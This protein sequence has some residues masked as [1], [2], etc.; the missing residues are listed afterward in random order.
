MVKQLNNSLFNDIPC[1]VYL[2]TNAYGVTLDA[3]VAIAGDPSLYSQAIKILSKKPKYSPFLLI[4]QVEGKQIPFVTP[5]GVLLLAEAWGNHAL[6]SLHGWLR[7]A[8]HKLA[9]HEEIEEPVLHA[10]AILQEEPPLPLHDETDRKVLD[11]INRYDGTYPWR[12][13]VNIVVDLYLLTSGKKLH[14]SAV[15]KDVEKTLNNIYGFVPTQARKEM[16]ADKEAALFLPDFIEIVG[17]DPQWRAITSSLLLALLHGDEIPQEAAAPRR[18]D[19]KNAA[20][21]YALV[22]PLAKA[23]GDQSPHQIVTLKEVFARM[24][25]DEGV[26]WK[27]SET[28]YKNKYHVTEP[29]KIDLI[30]DSTTR[31]YA[32]KRVVK[33]MLDETKTGKENAE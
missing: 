11:M 3:V 23:R 30:L 8:A 6:Y 26:D 2:V 15:L 24:A 32:F 22:E 28:R 27:R 19:T 18:K 1:P 21:L 10:P 9:R 17:D 25:R 31:Y 13:W 16:I 33:R 20:E 12:Q 14:R 5:E 4:E 7:R 29:A